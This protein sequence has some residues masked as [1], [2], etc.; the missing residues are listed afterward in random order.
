MG[1]YSLINVIYHWWIQGVAMVHAPPNW[2]Q[3]FHFHRK[4]PMLEVCTPQWFGIPP[5]RNPESATVYDK[6]S[7]N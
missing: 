4:V 1:I 3:F 6:C 2:I 5:M 7:S